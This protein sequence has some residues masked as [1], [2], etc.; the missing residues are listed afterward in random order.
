IGGEGLA[1][2]YHGRPELTAEKFI[3]DPFGG[4]AGARL[5]RTGDLVR[6]L[7]DGELEYLGRIDHQV[8][9]RGFRIE[10]GEVEAALES[11]GCVRQAVV[12]ARGEGAEKR[13]VAYLVSDE[14]QG[15]AALSELRTR[16]RERL[17]EFMVPS[18]FV[19]MDALPLT[20]NG[21]VDRK[22]L[23]EPEGQ[24]GKG[25]TDYAA[26]RTPTEE[27]L[28]GIWSEVL[29]IERVG[30]TDNF[31]DLGGHSL[32]ATRLISRMQEAFHVDVPLS[33]LFV[34]PTVRGLAE[35]VEAALGAGLGM[36]SPPL[37]RS[38]RGGP[39]PLSFA[40]QRL[41][42]LDQLEPGSPLYNIPLALR[43][44]GRL[45]VSALGRSVNEI[46]RRHE[47]LRTVFAETDGQ[48][49]QVILT[50]ARV[51]LPVIDL[52][53]LCEQAREAEVRRVA[54]AEARWRFD[55]SR[56]PLVRAT[57]M[58]LSEEEHVVCFTMH[59]IVSDGWSL[60]VMT[61]EVV[62]LYESFSSGDASPLAELP[63]QYA[64]YAEWQRRWLTGDVLEEQL[65]YWK[66]QLAGAPPVLELPADR[67][68]PAVQSFRGATENVRLSKEVSE[69]LKR[70]SR[71]EGATLFMTLLA[72][73]V[74]G[75]P[76]AGRNR[77]ETE[78][79]IGFFVNTLVLRTDLSGD[80]SFR[81]LVGRVREV[82]LGAYA[83]QDVPFEMLVEELQPERSLSHMPLFQVTFGFA[84]T[85]PPSPGTS[86][87]VSG[88]GDGVGNVQ[89]KFD[90]MLTIMDTGREFAGTFVY[91]TDLFEP[92]TVSRMA[93]YFE[94]LSASIAADP[95]RPIGELSLSAAA[96]GEGESA[97][98]GDAAEGDGASEKAGARLY[99][100]DKALRPVP[101]GIVG[102]IYAGEASVADAHITRAETAAGR[103]IPDP[104][105]GARG[106]RL[107]RTG[108]LA[109]Y[110]A[111]G[112]LELVRRTNGASEAA[113]AKVD[114][115]ET[116][117]ALASHEQVREALVT[118]HADGD[119]ET[120]LIAYVAGE[121]AR[122]D[123][124]LR[125][126]LQKRL[127]ERL[128]PSVVISTKTPPRRPGALDASDASAHGQQAA[129]PLEKEKKVQAR[130]A[131]L[132]ARRSKLS[133]AQQEK[134]KKRLQRE[135]APS[136]ET[137]PIPRRAALNPTP[138]S[139]AQQRLWFLDQL[140][141]GSPLY[142]IPGA[143]RLEGRLD[144]AA[145]ERCVNEVTRR[146]ESLRT[147]LVEVDGQPMQVVNPHARFTLPV[148]N[149]GSLSDSARE[150]EAR[151]LAEEEARR[152][153]DLSRGPLVRAALVRLSDRRHMLLFT[154]HHIVSDGW[155]MGVLLREVST[156]YRA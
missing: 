117:A 60:A 56:G 27:V 119:G 149:L 88:V 99:V 82:S 94:N 59:H 153:F 93:R 107:F 139:F 80:P 128:L 58:R 6:Y 48:P 100:L 50:A 64:D 57:L 43:L 95:D 134:L 35:R 130:R 144:V 9:V 38:P 11:V 133:A 102:E 152:P 24:E 86:L 143:L 21:K 129:R 22:A 30:V 29:R 23:P 69:E 79:L 87:R 145:L 73:I 67:P 112:T 98:A 106:A 18:A 84:P 61:R 90:L 45:H 46:V 111:D 71:R 65:S 140:E 124:E 40:Q 3:P 156:L 97:V 32:L 105:G 155:S 7:A 92:Q 54:A 74:V 4:E 154:M 5:Y 91:N 8:K 1:R 39:M 101:V 115:A 150:A 148:I 151:R 108:D 76:I 78:A 20:P 47:V 28:A 126:H 89:A 75:S 53:G 68:R 116:E 120:L 132:S 15:A 14:E 127:P 10:L 34:D 66:R 131:E 123:G 125:R 33:A 2:G 118:A 113:P 104:F 147:V 85:P 146:H 31:F 52:G 13:L 109:K 77:A 25:E 51:P 138:L 121:G 135:P 141:P 72:D 142:N 44:K 17:P 42:F 36:Q 110:R 55:L 114:A 26:P 62:L 70:L 83:H 96:Q 103:F 49:A 122:A 81:E 12:V 16:L 19:P 41:W 136:A 63:V 37:K 137:Q